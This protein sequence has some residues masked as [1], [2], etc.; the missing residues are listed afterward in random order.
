MQVVLLPAFAGCGRLMR[1]NVVASCKVQ[2]QQE[3]S[4]DFQLW[5]R[6]ETGLF[7]LI[8]NTL[9]ARNPRNDPLEQEVLSISLNMEFSHGDMV[10]FYL[11]QPNPLDVHTASAGNRSYLQWSSGPNRRSTLSTAD[12]TT[13]PAHLPI[14]NV[15]GKCMLVLDTLCVIYVNYIV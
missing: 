3:C 10:G 14:L 12:A 15:E 2:G 7:T 8:N 6:T 13:I 4:I 1:Y 11:S 5:R 9:T